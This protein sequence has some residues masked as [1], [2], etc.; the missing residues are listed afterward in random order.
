MVQ[1]RASKITVSGKLDENAWA[2][3][4]LDLLAT[5]GIEGV[6]VELLARS[7]GVTKGSFYWHFKDREALH[8]AML[9]RWRRQATLNLIQRLDQ[10]KSPESRLKELLR[11]PF[12]GSKSAKAA[13]IEL[14]VRLWGRSNSRAKT[15]LAEIDELRLEYIAQLLIEC[16]HELEEAK[17]R[18]VLAY[19]YM[20]VVTTLLDASNT[21]TLEL[22][23]KLLMM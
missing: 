8:M 1:K 21:E 6:R 3:A 14:A 4:G 12:A 18:A 5:K 23:E 20:R 10:H 17:A 19:S 22:C 11:I 7:L 16:G 2:S 13:E 9:E 15:V